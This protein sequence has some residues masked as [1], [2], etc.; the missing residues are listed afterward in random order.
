MKSSV[1]R[2]VCARHAA[3]SSSRS[4]NSASWPRRPSGGVRRKNRQLP[5][6]R[7]FYARFLPVPGRRRGRPRGH[8]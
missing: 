8:V 6:W 2:S 7:F 3:Q 1:R 4:V 5:R